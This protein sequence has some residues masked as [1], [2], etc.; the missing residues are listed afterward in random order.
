[1][2][3]LTAHRE[4][5]EVGAETEAGTLAGRNTNG[6]GEDIQNGEH[7]RSEQGQRGNLIQRQRLAR[8]ENSGRR[9]YK[10]LNQILNSASNNLTKIA[11]HLLIFKPKKIFYKAGC[12]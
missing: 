12:P 3:D 1:M 2:W 9:N 6:G 10:A 8:D 5:D 7:R 4:T 11:V